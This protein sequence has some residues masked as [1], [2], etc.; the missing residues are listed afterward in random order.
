[1]QS[2]A[3]LLLSLAA[4]AAAAPWEIQPRAAERDDSS[5]FQIYAYG[6]TIGGLPVFSAGGDAY[7]GDYTLFKDPNAA[8]VI[9]T[10]VDG[11]VWLAS[12]NTT[13]FTN[14]TA[15]PNW[16]KLTFS[17]PAEN[18][19]DHNVGLVGPD[20]IVSP[21]RRTSGFMFY[22][23]FIFVQ[24]SAGMASEWYAAPGLVDGVYSLK[25]A[26]NGPVTESEISLTL[27]KT[28]PSNSP[29]N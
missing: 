22:G 28:P 24:D 8:P 13:A 17:V 2:I 20:K 15:L 23:T 4:L 10:P 7:I 3:T 19:S 21:G 27:K 29:P 11:D 26:Q 1:M 18:S 12:P 14:R 6:D 25:W 5:P 9:F 16:S